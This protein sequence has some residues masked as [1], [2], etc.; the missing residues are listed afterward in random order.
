MFKN[1]S[2]WAKIF[3][4]FAVILVLSALIAFFGFQGLSRVAFRIT[5]ADIVAHAN[6]AML[7]A[8]QLE[9]NYILHGDLQ[10][11]DKVL[12]K[13]GSIKQM[14]LE[15][16]SRFND[17]VNLLQMDQVIQSLDAYKTAFSAFVD[18]DKKRT[19]RMAEIR[20]KAQKA[21]DKVEN[22]RKNQ[23]QQL[24]NI[25]KQSNEFIADKLYKSDDANRLFKMAL[26][27]KVLRVSLMKSFNEKD[28][29]EWKQLNSDIINL[30]LNLKK[31]FVYE[32]NIRQADSI[33]QSYN[34][35][36]D[37]FKR[38]VTDKKA[39]NA[40]E[41]VQS[42]AAAM[43]EMEGIKKDQYDQLIKSQEDQSV[44]M[45][46]KLTKLD[47]SNQIMRWFLEMRK[48]EKEY[49][50]SSESEYFKKVETIMSQ[51][52]E[53]LKEMK[54]RFKDEKNITLVDSTLDIMNDYYTA[55]LK[56]TDYMAQQLET[57]TSMVKAAQKAEKECMDANE[58]QKIKIGQRITDS[59]RMMMIASIMAIGLGLLLSFFLTRA[60]VSPILELSKNVSK[61]AKGDLTIALKNM[62][63]KDEIGV[64]IE[65]FNEMVNNLQ[66]QTKEM[67]E[68]AGTLAASISQ[69]SSTVAEMATSATETSSSVA[70]ITAT[71]EEVRQTVQVSNKKAGQVVEQSRR[72][73]EISDNGRKSTED[74]INGIKRIREEM[75]YIAESTVK[76]SEQ[77]QSIGQIINSVN[78]IADQSN[79]LSVNA[80][81]EAA[82]AGEHGKGFAV[83]AQEVKSLAEQSKE[84]TTKVTNILSDIQKAT[85]AAVMAT[86][87]GGKAVEIGV[88]LSAQA[89]EAIRALANNV[90][91]SSQAAL[92]IASSSQEQLV[93]MDQLV[94]AM[95]NIKEGSTQNAEG[96]R[97]LESAIQGLQ[98]L[99]SKLNSLSKKFTV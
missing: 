37:L 63:R 42:A 45:K 78:D 33:I 5:S 41:I 25:W 54:P 4:G 40:D 83:V 80:S 88:N 59:D 24:D 52:K 98:S 1:L 18:M 72:S 60:I 47:H 87:R 55:F 92:Q 11:V 71:V 53:L 30:T 90:K 74:T 68:G 15:A 66:I 7:E 20:Q 38:Y 14:V 95:G 8:R 77:T 81:I 22:I 75:E 16:K 64:L 19:E 35:Y 28:Y 62:E 91:E 57:N 12:D 79:L 94:E 17:K 67:T 6:I 48:N 46:D 27:A 2:L 10:L 82:K 9:K 99:A 96:A 97:Q 70:E 61:V 13:T 39:V 43:Q 76:L 49:I 50:L 84:S 31:R 51:I 58:D 26:E 23:K 29:S 86:E 73:E 34:H 93:G 85:S 44:M 65:G 32:K 56:Y 21:L 3:S 89:G 69:I 36:V